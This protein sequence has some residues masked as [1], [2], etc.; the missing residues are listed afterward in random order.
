MG[1]TWETMGITMGFAQQ[2]RFG[3][4]MGFTMGITM[5]F[6]WI[7][8]ENHQPMGIFW[9]KPWLNQSGICCWIHHGALCLYDGLWPF[10]IHF[11]VG[12][13]EKVTFLRIWGEPYIISVSG[14]IFHLRR[15]KCLYHHEWD[16]PYG[17]LGI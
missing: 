10:P 7:S 4:T 14:G 15:Q 9:G 8:H 17:H 2:T 1:I 6:A 11:H 3:F 16:S 13:L 12:L 5:G